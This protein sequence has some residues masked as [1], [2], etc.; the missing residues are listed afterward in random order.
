MA[1]NGFDAYSTALHEEAIAAQQR[2]GINY[3]QAVKL[4]DAKARQLQETYSESQPPLSGCVK[5][6]MQKD[7]QQIERE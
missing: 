5:P 7:I 4:L 2:F 6:L 3:D 1:T